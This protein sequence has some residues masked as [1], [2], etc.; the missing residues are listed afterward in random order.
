MPTI[1]G[2]DK[3]KIEKEK[4]EKEKEKKTPHLFSYESQTGWGWRILKSRKTKLRKNNNVE[5]DF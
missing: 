2:I 3:E 1:K 4:I 5:F